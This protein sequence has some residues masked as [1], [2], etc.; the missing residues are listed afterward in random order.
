M[1]TLINRGYRTTTPIFRAISEEITMKL[2]KNNPGTLGGTK[3]V[4]NIVIK[5]KIRAI[6]VDKMSKYWARILTL[7]AILVDPAPR[8][9]HQCALP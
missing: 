6:I 8:K 4:Q 3:T 9:Q 7:V 1:R 2:R 5:Y